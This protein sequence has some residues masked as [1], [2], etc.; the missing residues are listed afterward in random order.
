MNF[1]FYN[2]VSFKVSDLITK[3]Y[4]TSFSLA[5]N[6]FD[7]EL[8]DSISSIYGY[9]RLADEIVDSFHDFD[10]QNLINELREETY[11]SIRNGISL[12]P[13]IQSFQAT[14]NKYDISI[15]YINN[16]IDSM[17]MD[18]SNTFYYRDNYD[19]YIYGSAEVVG[20]MCLKVFC[21]R[22]DE[23][24][25][26]LI[27]S[28]KALG[29]AFQKVNFLRDIKSDLN[30][31]GRI[32][33]PDASCSTEINNEN[34]L[35]LEEEIEKEFKE[36][37]DGIKRLPKSSRLGVYSAYLYYYNLFKKIRSLKI[38]D[39]FKKRVRISNFTKLSLL[40]KSLIDIKL[41]KAI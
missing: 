32:Y 30:E 1:K 36:A 18:L 16:F 31:R 12:N 5:I 28:A 20:L 7:K 29:S 34:K 38:N 15:E 25:Q 6:V 24:F 2:D 9:V 8:R 40:A 10:K 37:L 35:L 33:L 3:S 14:V 41:I 23:L 19:K 13:I 26:S 22:Q 27:P 11:D 21:Y 39:L 17:E 4:S